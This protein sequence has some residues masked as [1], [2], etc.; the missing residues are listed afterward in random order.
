[1]S[2]KWDSCEI[3]VVAMNVERRVFRIENTNDT[4]SEGLTFTLTILFVTSSNSWDYLTWV[5]HVSESD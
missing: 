2:I 3:D 4:F 1:M 5:L